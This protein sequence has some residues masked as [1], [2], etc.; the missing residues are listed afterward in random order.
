MTHFVHDDA[1]YLNWLAEHPEGFVI[2]S[3]ALPALPLIAVRISGMTVRRSRHQAWPTV[4][5]SAA[6]CL[7]R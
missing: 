3:P 2:N 5:A 4:F 6:S 1:G 7:V